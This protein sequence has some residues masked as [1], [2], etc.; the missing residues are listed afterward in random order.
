VEDRF[1]GIV[2]I[3]VEIPR[4]SGNKYGYDERAGILRLDRGAWQRETR[5]AQRG[6]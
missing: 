2:E 1:P 3:V 5:A 4:G 6:G